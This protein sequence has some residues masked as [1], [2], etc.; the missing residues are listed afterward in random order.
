MN[1][2][3]TVEQVALADVA[4]EQGE[5]TAGDFKKAYGDGRV[6][7]VKCNVADEQSFKGRCRVYLHLL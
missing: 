6:F 4:V 5:A 2:V 1:C 3:I 7:F